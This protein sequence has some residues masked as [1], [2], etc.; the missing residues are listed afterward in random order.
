MVSLR[1]KILTTLQHSDCIVKR[2][3]SLIVTCFCNI[4]CSFKVLLKTL[5]F[6]KKLSS[7][8]FFFLCLVGD[9]FLVF[10]SEYIHF[11]LVK[12][13]FYVIVCLKLHIVLSFSLIVCLKL[14]IVVLLKD[15]LNIAVSRIAL[16]KYACAYVSVL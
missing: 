8:L 5:L 9:G 15:Y 13:N 2:N 4:F 10:I 7:R 11:F 14:D 6:F 12:L 1:Q 16:S 3:N